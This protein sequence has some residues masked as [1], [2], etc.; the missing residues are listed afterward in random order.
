MQYDIY[1]QRMDL[2]Q[3]DIRYR[4][5]GTTG[6]RLRSVTWIVILLLM[7]FVILAC[8]FMATKASCECN[9]A[10]SVQWP[11]LVP[12]CIIYGITWPINACYVLATIFLTP[13][14]LILSPGGPGWSFFSIA[15][16]PNLMQNYLPSRPFFNYTVD[17]IDNGQTRCKTMSMNTL[18]GLTGTSDSLSNSTFSELLSEPSAMSSASCRP[19][20]DCDQNSNPCAWT[21]CANCPGPDCRVTSQNLSNSCLIPSGS[22]TTSKET[23]L[24]SFGCDSCISNSESGM[25]GACFEGCGD[26]L[27]DSFEDCSVQMKE[28]PE[29]MCTPSLQALPRIAKDIS[30][31]IAFAIANGFI[32]LGLNTIRALNAAINIIDVG[33][34]IPPIPEP[35]IPLLT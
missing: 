4:T 6:K 17:F 32:T 23:S 24:K 10:Y 20:F 8:F 14:F 12:P 30:K 9:I 29:E 25:S 27:G 15:S 28:S 16:L 7:L 1:K 34:I 18:E 35:N 31:G 19:D 5:R 13:C 21:S 3:E 33:N 11:G 2:L 22:I 26:N